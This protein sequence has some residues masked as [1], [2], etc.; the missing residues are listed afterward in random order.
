MTE[1]VSTTAGTV[2]GYKLALLG[3]PV[4]ASLVAFW[5]G[6]RYVPLREGNERQD[7]INRIMACLVC[8]L[9]VGVC[10]LVLAM[11]HS[12]WI[13]EAGTRLAHAASLPGE[14]G[15]FVIT[16]CVFIACGI[17]GP[18]IVAAVYLWF[19]RRRGKD[20][21]ELAQDAAAGLRNNKQP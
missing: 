2:G 16:A 12:P 4:L 5:L 13:F 14:A 19:E 8:S 9:V 20:I 17:P 10:L 1:P 3:L 7:L 21:A 11:Q 6:L 18:W 15:F